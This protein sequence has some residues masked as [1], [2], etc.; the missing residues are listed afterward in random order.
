M[1]EDSSGAYLFSRSQPRSRQKR[2]S[3]R[4]AAGMLIAALLLLTA[5]VCLLVVFLPRGGQ[6][7]ASATHAVEKTFYFLYT[8][9]CTDRT[10]AVASAA[11]T[12]ERG[13]A[14]YIHND[15]TYK[16]VAAVYA[17]ESDVKTLVTVNPE[18]AYF[19]L[20]LGKLSAAE[21]KTAEY[22]CGEWFDTMYLAAT[23]LDRGNVTESAA[24]RAVAVACSKLARLVVQSSVRM[25]LAL[26]NSKYEFTDR[27]TV[28]SNIRY[29][30]A[31][32]IISAF[33]ASIDG[34]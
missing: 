32:V 5:G 17:R 23:E 12:S 29:I 18:S 15:G 11:S 27:R 26:P 14:G 28:L 1:R 20:S 30:T 3:A 16:T 25:E 33:C 2:R 6:A 34:E 31:D 10:Q 21:R 22:I 9:E 8:S 4:R 7:P 24:E 19:S 13:G